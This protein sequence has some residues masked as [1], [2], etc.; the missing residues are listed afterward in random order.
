MNAIWGKVD[1]RSAMC[2]LVHVRVGGCGCVGAP[3]NGGVGESVAVRQ[4][5]LMS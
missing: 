5:A 2:L 3:E 4:A 1:N